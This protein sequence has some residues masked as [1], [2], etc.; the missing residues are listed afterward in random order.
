MKMNNNDKN[1]RNDKHPKLIWIAIFMS[2][3][4]TVAIVIAGMM[5]YKVKINGI[6]LEKTEE[7]IKY[8]K[9]YA[10]IIEDTDNPFWDNV[11]EGAKEKGEQLNTY[12][13]K[14]GKAL[15][16]N[17]TV[18][19]LLK[20]AILANVD[21]I[22]MQ[23][24]SDEETQLLINE[25]EQS[26]IPVATVLEDSFQSGRT[27]FV[28]VNNYQLGKEY[29]N[30]VLEVA[31]EETQKVMVLLDSNRNDAS[32]DL[33]LS[34][35]NDTL[36]GSRIEVSVTTID[37]KSA[38]SS[39]EAIHDIMLD[40]ENIPDILICLNLTDT[41]CAYQTAVDYNKVGMIKII[42]YYNSGSI[43]QAIKKEI[44]HSTIVIDTKGM[45]AYAVE[46]LCEYTNTKRVSEY[47]PV[48]MEL[49][50]LENI[51]EE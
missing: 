20:I 46:A 2:T 50:S 17:Y 5:Y 47:I 38:F 7:Y 29:G 42:G 30:Q 18:K 14:F 49:I 19:E 28:G 35:I 48:D 21:G 31:D 34:G 11:Y 22:I 45:G 33:V 25:A 8:E 41:I 3:L 39:E 6:G 1:D 15:P 27:C 36:E 43:S 16:I 26:G 32:S 37:R 10:F 40:Q 23:G 51:S 4:I 13:E 9:H 12:V 24:N 44:I